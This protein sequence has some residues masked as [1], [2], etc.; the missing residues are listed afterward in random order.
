MN[1]VP[2]PDFP[3]GAIII[4]NEVSGTL[5]PQAEAAW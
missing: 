5:M 4:G 3:T 1:F 2:G